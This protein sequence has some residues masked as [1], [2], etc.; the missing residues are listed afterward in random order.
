MAWWIG[1]HVWRFGIVPRG[2]IWI[3]LLFNSFEGSNEGRQQKD[4]VI[5]WHLGKRRLRGSDLWKPRR[6]LHL[7]CSY[8]NCWIHLGEYLVH[9]SLDYWILSSNSRN[10]LPWHTVNVRS[11]W[12]VHKMRRCCGWQG[13]TAWKFETIARLNIWWYNMVKRGLIYSK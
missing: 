12:G 2:E 7:W 13:W 5:W 10:T 4:E 11:E 8:G 9:A 1:S 3:Y 6:T